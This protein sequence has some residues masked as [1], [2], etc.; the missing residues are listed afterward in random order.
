MDL[1]SLAERLNQMPIFP[2]FTICHV[3]VCT[4]N[5]RSDL[6][7]GEYDWHMY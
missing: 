1:K 6:G 3:I 2:F 5:V 7:S 4:L